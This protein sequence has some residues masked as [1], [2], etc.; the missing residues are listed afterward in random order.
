MFAL[1][2]RR[3]VRAFHVTI[4]LVTLLSFTVSDLPGW[5]IIVFPDEQST[6]KE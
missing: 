1:Q 2:C 4:Q 5:R 6:N 3:A